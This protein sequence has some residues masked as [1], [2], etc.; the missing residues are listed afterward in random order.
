MG[1]ARLDLRQRPPLSERSG[2]SHAGFEQ[3]IADAARRASQIQLVT[4]GLKFTH[5][6]ARGTSVFSSGNNTAKS[7]LVGTH[8]LGLALIADGV[9]SAGALDVFKFLQ[10]EVA[11]RTLLNRIMAND[12]QLAAVHNLELEKGN[13]NRATLAVARKLVAYLLAVDKSGRPFQIP[14]QPET[15]TEENK[16]A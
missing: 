10:I 7:H 2:H 14:N 3:W 9:C 13:R 8:I 16:V 4:H 12:P 6:D 15:G 5:P 11:G 1:R